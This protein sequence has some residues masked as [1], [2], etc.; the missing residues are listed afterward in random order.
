MLFFDIGGGN[1]FVSKGL[2]KNGIKTCLV[3]PGIQGCLNAK[4]RGLSNI[5]CSDLESLKF[6][7]PIPFSIGL[8]D[9]LEHIENDDD[10][11]EKICNSI[12]KDGYLFITVPAYNFLWS[13]QD[14]ESGHFRRYSLYELK[15]K[16]KTVGF[17]ILYSTYIF[18]FLVLP[19]FFFAHC[20]AAL[21]LQ[22]REQEKLKKSIMLAGIVF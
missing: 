8:F 12:I 7:A 20:Q 13:K 2:E 14:T 19:I 9:V 16:L 10:Y 15:N 3:E 4:K 18:S 11:L 17:E 1:G 5:V 21:E 22:K 6:K